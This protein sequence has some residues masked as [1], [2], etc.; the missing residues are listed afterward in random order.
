MMGLQCT[1]VVMLQ[2]VHTTLR[3]CYENVCQKDMIQTD[4]ETLV[5]YASTYCRFKAYRTCPFS[6]NMST[7]IKTINTMCVLTL[8]E[9]QEMIP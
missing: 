9:F 1:I 8:K 3:C 7:I 6:S 2:S 5:I 4:I